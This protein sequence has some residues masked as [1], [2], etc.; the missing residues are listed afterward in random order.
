MKFSRNVKG[1]R[2]IGIF[3]KGLQQYSQYSF[4]DEILKT[5]RVTSLIV[6]WKSRLNL[7]SYSE[8]CHQKSTIIA[9][10]LMK[11]TGHLIMVVLIKSYGKT[12]YLKNSFFYMHIENCKTN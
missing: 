8:G 7:L 6:I 10:K 3:C 9:Y 5:S 2:P 11:F 1:F 12:L 4:F